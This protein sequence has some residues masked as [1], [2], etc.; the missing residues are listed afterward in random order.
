MTGLAAKPARSA[1]DLFFAADSEAVSLHAHNGVAR[2]RR[3]IDFDPREKVRRKAIGLPVLSQRSPGLMPL[4]PGTDDVAIVSC[5]YAFL[6][7]AAVW[8][9]PPAIA[10]LDRATGHWLRGSR[11]DTTKV[12][13]DYV[14]VPG[15]HLLLCDF[16]RVDSTPAARGRGPTTTASRSPTTGR[17]SHCCGSTRTA[18]ARRASSAGPMR[19]GAARAT[20]SH[21]P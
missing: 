9:D 20:P 16:D 18:R 8:T 14:R 4:G 6:N 2:R 5:G 7:G 12:V 21:F 11:I 1:D 15:G 19:K 17:R 13:G 10:P 3:T